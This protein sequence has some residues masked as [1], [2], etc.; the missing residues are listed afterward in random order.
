MDN[1]NIILIK[2]NDVIFDYTE[3]IKSEP[4]Y[5]EEHISNLIE[6]LPVTINNMMEVIINKIGLTSEIFGNTSKCLDNN[7]TIY[8][9]CHLSDKDAHQ[10]GGDNAKI[11][12]LASYMVLGKEAIYGPVMLVKSDFIENRTC[13]SSNINGLT[14]TCN[15]LHQRLIHTCIQLNSDGTH[16]QKSFIESP[17][18]FLSEYDAKNYRFIE[19]NFLNFNF[20]IFVQMEPDVKQINKKATRLSGEHKIF[21]TAILVCKTTENDFCNITL[22]MYKKI[23]RTSWGSLKNRD[24]LAHEKDEN[25]KINNLDII[26]NNFNILENR[27]NQINNISEYK[28]ICTGCY[29]VRY[30]TPEDQKQDWDNH[31][32]ECLF[33]KP[34]INSYIRTKYIVEQEELL[35]KEQKHD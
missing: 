31:K 28:C 15:L 1:F 26:I 10:L 19:A 9:I 2:P 35:A 16:I 34:D 11:N 3:L 20:V 22:D 12:R 32:K 29:R 23:D 24:I 33:E 5:F 30:M 17:A 7:D 8:Q 18:E 27:Y 14:E 4:N 6:I 25:K 21:G 13:I